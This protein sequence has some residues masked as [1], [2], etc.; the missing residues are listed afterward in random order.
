MKPQCVF[1]RLRGK[2]VEIPVTND[3]KEVAL[4]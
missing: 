3:N 4:G 2:T 1:I